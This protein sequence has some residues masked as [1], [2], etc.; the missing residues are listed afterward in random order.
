MCLNILPKTKNLRSTQ[1]SLPPTGAGEVQSANEDSVLNATGNSAGSGLDEA[2]ALRAQLAALNKKVKQLESIQASQTALTGD[3][4]TTASNNAPKQAS[5]P[6]LTG[7]T[8]A[9]TSNNVQDKAGGEQTST[10]IDQPI[11]SCEMVHDPPAPL[12]EGTEVPPASENLRTDD[13]DGADIVE[14]ED[15]DGV[16]TQKSV[17]SPPLDDD[18]DQGDGD[19][20]DLDDVDDYSALSE[21]SDQEEFVEQEEDALDILEPEERLDDR[22]STPNRQDS[23]P[24]DSEDD[25]VVSVP[26]E[27]GADR[28]ERMLRASEEIRHMPPPAPRTSRDPRVLTAAARAAGNASKAPKSQMEKKLPPVSAKLPSPSSWTRPSADVALSTPDTNVQGPNEIVADPVPPSSSPAPATSDVV[29]RD[30]APAA[31]EQASGSGAVSERSSL[32]F[33]PEKFKGLIRI[34]PTS[35][36]VVQD[37]REWRLAEDHLLSV[38]TN[39]KGVKEWRFLK[40]FESEGVFYSLVLP[41]ESLE[42]RWVSGK[43][44]VA[45]QPSAREVPAAER[46]FASLK[47]PPRPSIYEAEARRLRKKRILTFADV[48][49]QNCASAMGWSGISD[50]QSGVVVKELPIEIRDVLEG[51]RPAR[52][53]SPPVSFGFEGLK[54]TPAEG[55]HKAAYGD[56]G[57]TLNDFLD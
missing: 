45:L 28:M 57:K 29:P 24:S 39:E 21:M 44:L 4:V 17:D 27:I 38:A 51:T 16:L 3:A 13:L 36:R 54:D 1:V 56:L 20:I 37:E 41:F 12:Q 50:D 49:N 7:E 9:T 35:S 40:G 10:A 30:P 14:L 43:R 15:D 8:E 34:E 19:L 53:S 31:Q 33:I 11:G 5:Q 46:A 25:S 2:S 26:D 6:A 55:F 22:S 32:F 18:V 42:E 48:E 47:T 52:P 23:E